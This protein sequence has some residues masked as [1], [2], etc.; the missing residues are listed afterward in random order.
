MIVTLVTYGTAI[1]LTIKPYFG[2]GL[3]TWQYDNKGRRLRTAWNN[4]KVMMGLIDDSQ[5]VPHC[6]RHTCASRLVQ[7]GI[8]LTTVKEWLGHKSIQ[9]TL[10]YAHLSPK[11]LLDAVHVLET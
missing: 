8:Q 1:C 10:R 4:A 7:R 11:N 9:V 5:F 6:L 3:V 2:L